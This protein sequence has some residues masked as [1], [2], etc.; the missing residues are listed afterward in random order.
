MH[1]T[2]GPLYLK[3]SCMCMHGTPSPEPPTDMVEMMRQHHSES[4][5]PEI[6][7]SMIYVQ[8]QEKIYDRGTLK[9]HIAGHRDGT[10][11]TATRIVS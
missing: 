3:V 11:V 1:G 9:L 4:A 6:L 8:G 7:G 5:D 2:T 10:R